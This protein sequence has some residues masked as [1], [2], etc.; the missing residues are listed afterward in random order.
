MALK[1]R[2]SYICCASDSAVPVRH[3]VAN[4]IGSQHVGRCV[5]DSLRASAVAK[6]R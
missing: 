4:T 6:I 3:S 5:H 1:S 2:E